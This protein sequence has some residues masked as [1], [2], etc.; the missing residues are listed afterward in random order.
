MVVMRIVDSLRVGGACD[1]GKRQQAAQQ[2]SGVSSLHLDG[3][4]FVLW[5]NSLSRGTW[6][7]RPFTLA[8]RFE[9]KHSQPKPSLLRNLQPRACSGNPS[10]PG[11]HNGT[12]S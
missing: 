4:L 2:G 12:A 8:W 5:S 10:F 7:E 3:V 6:G 1:C 11:R 9:A